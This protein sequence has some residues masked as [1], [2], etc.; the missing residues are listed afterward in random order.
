M[1]HADYIL[2]QS[3]PFDKNSII[4]KFSDLVYDVLAQFKLEHLDRLV[5]SVDKYVSDDK[6]RNNLIDGII[7]SRCNS[8]KMFSDISINEQFYILAHLNLGLV[9]PKVEEP[10]PVFVS[11]VNSFVRELII[12]S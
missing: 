9:T 4:N 3:R 7:S 8:L 10:N 5:H 6:V 12:T 11:L 2:L 1:F